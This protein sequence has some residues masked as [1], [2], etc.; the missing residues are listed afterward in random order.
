[1]AKESR[2]GRLVL[3]EPLAPHSQFGV[4]GP[5]DVYGETDDP[6]QLCRWIRDAR[7]QGR[8]VWPLGAGSNTL[9][10]DGG[11][12]ALV[13]KYTKKGWSQISPDR[14]SV[15]GGTMLPRLAYDLAKAGIAGMEFAVGVPG[16]MGGSVRGNAGAFGGV[17]S[18]DL[19]ECTAV[20]PSGD[21]V[22]LSCDQLEM[23]Y[24]STRFKRDWSDY[25]II[26][27]DFAVGVGDSREL[28]ARVAQIKETRHT[29]QP[30]GVRSLGSVFANPPG[31][32]AGRLLEQAGMKGV[33]RGGAQVAPTHA[34]FILN[35]DHATAADVEALLEEGAR[36]VK[37]T[38]GVVLVPEIV[39]VGE[40]L[41]VAA[42]ETS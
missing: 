28:V 35:V 11:V 19:I 29:T 25:L 33:T 2:K 40:K 34:N 42:G 4:G 8:A 7:G 24:R 36:R 14:I 3:D 32:F 39:V 17:I 18:E 6:E 41:A 26:S 5:A 1:M 27:A 38:A 9:I 37:D 12:R 20:T 16:T 31:D 15:D 23:S 22:H 30:Q 21:E 10:R 13:V